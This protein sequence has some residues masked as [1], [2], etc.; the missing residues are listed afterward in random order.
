MAMGVA[1]AFRDASL[2]ARA[3]DN[4]LSG[5][6]PLDESLAEYETLR[7]EQVAEEYQENLKLARLAGPSLEALQLRA[8]LKENPEQINLFARVRGL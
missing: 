6:A 5:R 2:L 1:D 3:I 8:A 7:N 4:G